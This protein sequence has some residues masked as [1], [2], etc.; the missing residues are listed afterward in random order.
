VVKV[1]NSTETDQLTYCDAEI[2]FC[3]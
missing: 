3:L 1:L 2:S